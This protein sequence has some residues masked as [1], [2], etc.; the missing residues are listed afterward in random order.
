MLPEII[1]IFLFTLILVALLVPVGRY[2]S[3]RTRFRGKRVPVREET[4]LD[5]PETQE[6]SIGMTMVFFFLILFPLILA[7]NYWVT[8]YGPTFMEISWVPVVAI[9]ILLALLIAAVSPRRPRPTSIDA[10]ETEEDVAAGAA[11]LFGFSF[12]VLLLLSLA[13]IIVALV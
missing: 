6:V 8:P 4:E 5:Q 2:G 3:F 9:G 7:G 13:V 11:A 12:F 10:T 1:F